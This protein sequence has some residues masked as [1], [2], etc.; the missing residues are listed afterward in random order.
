MQIQ[1]F[2][3]FWKV[4]LNY[5]FKYQSCSAIYGSLGNQ[6]YICWIFCSPLQLPSL[7][8]FLL[9]FQFPIHSFNC[10]PF[11]NEPNYNVR[12]LLSLYHIVIILCFCLLNLFSEFHEPSLIFFQFLSIFVFNFRMFYFHP[13][14]LFEGIYF[15]VLPYT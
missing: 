10:F 2:S 7:R 12:I 9:L 14:C 1:I 13:K 15:E 4:F 8:L 11:F 5:S 6:L 3:N